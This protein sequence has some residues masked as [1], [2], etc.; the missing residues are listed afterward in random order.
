M[1][2]EKLLIAIDGNSLMHRAFYALPSMTNRDGVPTGAVYGF[3][4]MLISLLSREPDYLVVAFDLH[5]PTFRHEQYGEYKAGRRET[6]EELRP[7][8]DMLKEIIKSMGILISTCPS[9]EADDILGTFSR[10][11]GEQGVKSLLVTGDRDAL[12]LIDKTTHVLLTKKGVSET[13]EMDEEALMEQYGLTPDKMRD[14][15]GLMGDSSDNIP[16]IPGVGEKTALKL[17]SEYGSMEGVLSHAGEI[18]GKLGEKVAANAELAHLS[19]ELGT[20]DTLAPIKDTLLDSVFNVN[21]LNGG[22]PLMQKAELFS[23][24]KRLPK[25]D[26][27]EHAVAEAEGI[28]P[29]VT[30]DIKDLLLLNTM[31]NEFA[32]SAIIALVAEGGEFFISAGPNAQYRISAGGTL[33]DM[34]LLPDQVFGALKPAL[35]DNTIKKIVFDAKKWMHLLSGYGIELNGLCFDAMIG[36]YLLNAIRPA[37]SLQ[38]LIAT[39]FQ[40][41]EANAALLFRLYEFMRRE[42]ESKGLLELYEQIEQPLIS[43]LYDM[44]KEGFALDLG[45]LKEMQTKFGE[46][47]ACLE[48]KIYEL[49]GGEFNILSPKQLG[50]LLFEKL[51]LPVQRK[52]KTGYSTDADVLDQLMDLH[53]VVPL[54]HEY[55]TLS[56]LKSTF[57]DGLVNAVNPSSGRVHTSFNQN[58][59]ATGRISS[60]EPNLQNIPVRTEMGRE[61]RKA[62]IASE[63]NVL[64]GADYSQIELRLLAHI[65]GDTAMISAFNSDDDI[66]TKTASEVFG[67]AIDEVTWEQ[68]SAAKAVNFGIVYG[69]SDF[70]L[71]RNLGISRRQAGEYIEKYL[72]RYPGVKNFMHKSVQDGKENGYVSTLTGRRRDLPEL[73][74]SQY[75]TR[76]FG[77]R[78]AM[79]MPIQG[80]AADII[81]LAMVRV[82]SALKESGLKAKLILQVHDELLFDVPPEEQQQVMELACECMQGA[83]EL[84]VP[85]I[86]DV[87]AGKSWYDTK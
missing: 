53:P 56:K 19:Y 62:F 51:Q 35:E 12:Q 59:T 21:T 67:V 26:G 47:I 76:S 16:G 15:K 57:I 18:K 27:G 30:T 2:K 31:V 40:S 3:L 33:L 25:N 61:I 36:D 85:L 87:R 77:E 45:V 22:I 50:T 73:K 68:R 43:V 82:H 58:V 79:N 65:S 6:P 60:V 70:G 84:S 86:A 37:Q 72:N 4:S 29:A 38:T 49:S 64:V 32:K 24:I 83:M 48:T 80:S 23:L 10:I 42:L 13:M 5:G 8:F 74:S 28:T 17:L 52:T 63:G 54:I 69:I 46:D 75:N 14:L 71:S 20:I 78:V 66:H 7:Q 34:G 11:A 44:E 9:F 39:R 55:R 41:Q 81:K 1:K